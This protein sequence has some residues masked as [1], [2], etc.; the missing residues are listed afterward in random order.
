[1]N[2]RNML[3][4]VAGGMI[5]LACATAAHAYDAETHGLI[6]YKAFQAS[7]LNSVASGSVVARLGLDRL[8]APTPFNAYWIAPTVVPS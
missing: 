2:S 7:T 3:A 6:T 5:V 8:D 4:A 1:M